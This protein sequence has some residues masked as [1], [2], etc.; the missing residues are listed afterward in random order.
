M[1]KNVDYYKEGLRKNLDKKYDEAMAAYTKAI[2]LDPEHVDS[3]M[4][5]GILG[6]RIL[7]KYKDALLDFEKAAQLAP[8]RADTY[9]HRGIVKCHLLQFEE[10]LRDFNKAAE[11][12]PNDERIY[13]NRGKVK[14][15]LKFDKDDV[16]DDLNRSLDLGL[17]QAGDLITL[18]YGNDQNSV[19]RQVDKKIKKSK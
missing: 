2:G 14:Y 5:R 6:Y 11:R 18:F 3:Y 17:A 12:A 7:K 16:C 8:E 13:F 1:K 15:V 10:G 4:Q 19:N 9:L